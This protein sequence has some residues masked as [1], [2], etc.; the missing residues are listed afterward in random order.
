MNVLDIFYENIIKEA[1]QG[2]INCWFYHNIIFSTKLLEDNVEYKANNVDDELF[3]PTLIIKNKAEFEKLLKEYIYLA[4]KFYPN[5]QFEEEILD[6]KLY[7]EQ[8]KICKEKTL[9]TY[10]FANATNEDFN[11]INEY[12]RKRINFFNNDYTGIYNLGCS[13]ILGANL[14]VHID[15]DDYHNETPYKFTLIAT[16][17]ND[18][19]IF[20]SVKFGISDN[21]LY[22]YA[23]QNNKQDTT[24][25]TKKINRALYK[26][27][28]GF[29]NNLDNYDIYDLG[30][31]KD[32]T[33]NFVVSANVL[34][35]FF[36]QLGIKDII[37]PSILIERYNAKR[38]YIINRAKRVKVSNEGLEQL[39]SE[40][41]RI[42]SNLTEKLLR[43]FLR[44]EFHFS[45]IDVY[46]YPEEANNNLCLKQN[47]ELE[48]NNTLLL[49]T[50]NLASN[51][52][53]KKIIR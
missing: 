9:M 31:L 37:V 44:L 10:L 5:Y 42:Q 21:K 1:S 35:S 6:Y 28:E 39:K 24:S 34:L 27:G 25:F 20:P 29:D 38:T 53:D 22:V 23:I 45:N 30:N 49:E 47:N 40:Q 19:Y 15:K 51:A 43:T 12:L 33:P 7:D 48:C 52:F 11:N 13:D 36:N 2:T 32:I 14:E 26:V 3:V 50:A 41:L 4:I 16:N 46:A 18:S 17:E 8:D